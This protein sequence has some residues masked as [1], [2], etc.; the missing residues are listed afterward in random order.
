[1]VKVRTASLGAGALLLALLLPAQA[2]W[3]VTA[4]E[5][6]V[7]SPPGIDAWHY[8]LGE[9]SSGAQ[10][11]VQLALFSE[12]TATLQVV[13][14]PD[15]QSDLAPTMVR[16]RCLAGVNGGYFDPAGAPVGLL[17]SDGKIVSHFQKARL[18]SGVL[19]VDSLGVK[20]FRAAEFPRKRTWRAAV[21][22]GPFLVDRGKPVAGLND[23]RRARR[24]FALTTNDHRAALGFCESVTLAQLGE[25]V[26]ALSSVSINRALNLDGGSSSAFWVAGGADIS[27]QKT[28]RDFVA[29]VPR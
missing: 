8:S 25:I 14:Q 26:A 10:T 28:V 11:E 17:V 7:S 22:C 3:Q 13:D 16:Q 1:M 20:I 12:K 21:Q 23:T 27:E 9:T 2:G 24:T 5:K 4:L 29:I 15:F 6:H 19:A 18:L